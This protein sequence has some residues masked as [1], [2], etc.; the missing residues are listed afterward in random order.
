MDTVS[1][2]AECLSALATTHFAAIILDLGLPDGDGLTVLQ[3]LRGKGSSI[4]VL[5]LTAR[6]SVRDRVQGL[7][8]GA[9]DYL[10]KPFAFE[11][12][13]ARVRALLRRPA[14]YLGRELRS[15]ISA[16][17]LGAAKLPLMVQ[18]SPWRREKLLCWKF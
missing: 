14:A 4:P 7:H 13:V 16:S 3:Y 17:M 6:L 11:E 18:S 12:L 9:D 8:H 5:V 2:V 15:G 1:T 10:G